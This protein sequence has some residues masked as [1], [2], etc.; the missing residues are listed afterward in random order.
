[1]KALPELQYASLRNCLPVHTAVKEKRGG[2]RGTASRLKRGGKNALALGE[3]RKLWHPFQIKNSKMIRLELQ[4][5]AYMTF[6][7]SVRKQ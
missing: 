1:M 2:G 6:C 3:R 7:L 4:N 5:T